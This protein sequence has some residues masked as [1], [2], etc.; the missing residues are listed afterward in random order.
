MIKRFKSQLL[1]LASTAA[2]CMGTADAHS[3]QRFDNIFVFGDSSADVGNVNIPAPN[4]PPVLPLVAPVAG[5]VWTQA[6]ASH[7]GITL[8]RSTTAGGTDF[9]YAGAMLTGTRTA[10]FAALPNVGTQIAGYLAANNNHAD[11]RALYTISAGVNDIFNYLANGQNPAFFPGNPGT[12][13]A[14]DL[15]ALSRAGAR[16]FVVFNIPDLSTTPFGNG[17][18]PAA[19]AGIASLVGLQNALLISGVA[20]LNQS[21][22]VFDVNS[23]TKYILANPSKFGF[24]NV[25][26]P[27]A[28]AAGFFFF[29]A[30][31]VSAA[32]SQIIGDAVYSVVQAPY[33]IATIAESS[34]NQM[35]VYE[36]VINGATAAF[37]RG[38][39]KT[40]SI[41]PIIS[42]S[43]DYFKK[44]GKGNHLPGY[45]SH[46]AEVIV[47]A[48]MPILPQ[49]DV[50]L[51]LGQSFWGKNKFN[52]HGGEF[53]LYQSRAVIFAT[54]NVG[55]MHWAV[56]FQGSYLGIHDIKRN[57]TLGS[58]TFKTHADTFGRLFGGKLEAGYWVSKSANFMTGPLAQ[59][60]FQDGSINE[61][62]EKKAPDG[63]NLRYFKQNFR[64]VTCALGWEFNYKGSDMNSWAR[65]LGNVEFRPHR[66]VKARVATLEE[67]FFNTRVS[68][69]SKRPW[70]SLDFGVEKAV[71][72]TMGAGLGASI[73]GFRKMQHCGN[74]HSAMINAKITF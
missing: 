74:A 37:R 61:F 47:G 18:L 71:S 5:K 25:T 69:V 58:N 68:E 46:N 59:A 56:D 22:I 49:L 70:A 8:V 53:K 9:A 30:L 36:S 13:V 42:I 38:E 12:A 51:V 39:C 29:D 41:K 43:Y 21:V 64:T 10:P 40:G 67:T 23:F 19:K 4:V 28:N 35:S 31:N 65:L 14:A 34:L 27:G 57:I 62:H 26:A 72:K 3:N 17:Q 15:T 55:C 48:H 16:N 63:L 44:S 50:G 54:L 45:H 32:A 52:N 1:A 33:Y 6:F 24:T 20:S 60:A 7:Y 11:R 73:S 2:V 66:N